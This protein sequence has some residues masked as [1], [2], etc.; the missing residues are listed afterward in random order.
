M[1]WSQFLV[2]LWIRRTTMF[3]I[4]V[5]VQNRQGPFFQLV[6]IM[7][8]LALNYCTVL[9]GALIKQLLLR[10]AYYFLTIVDDRS[11]ATWVYLMKEKSETTKILINFF[12]MVKNQYGQPVKI[13]RSDNG[14]EFLSRWPLNDFLCDNGIT[15]R[16]RVRIVRSKMV[17]LNRNIDICLMW[18]VLYDFK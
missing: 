13:L 3:T 11:R 5:I 16:L 18:H 15:I 14:R 17:E 7:S 12:K 2:S 9:F 6:R 8:T 1:C 4:F 10:G